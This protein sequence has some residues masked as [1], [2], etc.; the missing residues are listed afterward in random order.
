MYIKSIVNHCN[1]FFMNTPSSYLF[2]IGFKKILFAIQLYTLLSF[3]G[4]DTIR[5][6]DQIPT[7]I[8]FSLGG[9]EIIRNI[10]K[11]ADGGYIIIGK[12]NSNTTSNDI[13][14]IRTDENLKAEWYK[15]FGTTDEDIGVDA[16]ETT[17]GKIIVVGMINAKE[18]N[19]NIMTGLLSKDGE[20][21]KTR[22]Y[23]GSSGEEPRRI[24][25]HTQDTYTIISNTG[26]FGA[27]AGDIWIITVDQNGDSLNSKLYGTASDERVL[28][29][30]QT[31]DGGLVMTGYR[32]VSTFFPFFLKLGHD[33][34]EQVWVNYKSV[35][36][37]DEGVSIIETNAG[38]FVI[39]GTS[40]VIRVPKENYDAYILKVNSTGQLI[41]SQHF[42]RTR[43]DFI[44]CSLL[45]PDQSFIIGG[46]AYE[47][48]SSFVDNLQMLIAKVNTDGS[49]AWSKHI[50]KK[51]P[52]EVITL[53]KVSENKYFVGAN[54]INEV[55]SDWDIVL[56]QFD[57]FGNVSY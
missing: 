9:D 52:E 50:G 7:Q 31:Q 22:I 39:S 54:V 44:L 10:R 56:F 42:G 16:I 19:S 41:W 36:N 15:L 55:N 8:R 33:M 14:I 29:A 23:G 37:R 32:S 3:N 5:K 20:L 51:F 30:C 47:V 11:T 45:L 21:L 18:G 6:T 27:G 24:I 25:K 48:N 4:C 35:N 28:D 17:E 46:S 2:S 43:Y 53:I 34:N 13:L 40:N 38:D 1:V 57:E 26:S 49:I 12:S